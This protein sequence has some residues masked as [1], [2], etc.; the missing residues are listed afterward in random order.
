MI[1]RPEQQRDTPILSLVKT[2]SKTEQIKSDFTT[3]FAREMNG[4]L[5]YPEIIKAYQEFDYIKDRY[6]EIA[7]NK[8]DLNTTGGQVALSRH[9]PMR[10]EVGA[11]FNAME[12]GEQFTPVD[13]QA[14]YQH[15]KDL[16]QQNP[17]KTFPP[18]PKRPSD[19]CLCDPQ[20]RRRYEAE[21]R[22][23]NKKFIRN[24]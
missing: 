17:P 12:F 14:L 2:L 15:L 19:L 9:S 5:M 22:S 1:V 16:L 21:I 20:I 24:I 8:I 10:I 3:K 13:L 6:N 4:F 11:S 18:P 7:S 23:W